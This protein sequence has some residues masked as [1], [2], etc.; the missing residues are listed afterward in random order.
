MRD[1]NR[2]MVRG[3]GADLRGP[4]QEYVHAL[5]FITSI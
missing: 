1:C 5:R 2:G 3:F 4:H